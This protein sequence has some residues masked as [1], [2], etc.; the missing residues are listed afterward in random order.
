MAH[1]TTSELDPG[2]PSLLHICCN[3]LQCR[4]HDTKKMDMV[5]IY[6]PTGGDKKDIVSPPVQIR[7]YRRPMTLSYTE[8]G[9]GSSP[10][11]PTKIPPPMGVLLLN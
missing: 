8:K 4:F 5:D 7:H 2:L 3:R 11:A 9:R 10:F 6:T 1:L